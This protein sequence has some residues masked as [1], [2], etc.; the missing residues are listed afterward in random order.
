MILG[1]GLMATTFSSYSEQTDVMIFASGVSNSSETRVDTFNK[2]M[3]LLNNICKNLDNQ[4]LIYFSTSS[5]ADFELI[6]SPYVIH[7][8]EM[9]KFISK[10][11]NNYMIFRLP[12][13]VGKTKNP[14]TIVNFIYNHLMEGKQFNIWRNACRN[15]IDVT[16]VYHII[17]YFIQN[18]I[19]KNKVTTIATPINLKIIDIL[20]ILEK[21]TKKKANFEI[22]ERGNCYEIDIRHLI[23]YLE[24]LHI[25]FSE[26]YV[27]KIITKYYGC[28]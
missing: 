23:P 9:E 28:K 18:R 25:S 27:E 17:D 24:L 22:L 21:I 20:R 14:H 10:W 19:F 16:D 7:K 11:C 1:N 15:L 12:Q 6:G 4:L 26:E 8:L 5:I 3:L 2:E 13:I